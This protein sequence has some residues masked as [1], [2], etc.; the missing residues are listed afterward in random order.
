M[1]PM[2]PA[3]RKVYDF[4]RDYAEKKQAIASPTFRELADAHKLTV[5]WAQSMI[6]SLIT[7]GWVKNTPH[8]PRSLEIAREVTEAGEDE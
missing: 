4:I 3:E 1:K 2:T 5:S 8:V 6:S 7:K